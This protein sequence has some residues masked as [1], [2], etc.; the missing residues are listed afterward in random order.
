MSP[1]LKCIPWCDSEKIMW[2]SQPLETLQDPKYKYYQWELYN[3]TLYTGENH[4]TLFMVW[5]QYS[6]FLGKTLPMI[7]NPEYTM[8]LVSK[9]LTSQQT[10][11][12]I[13]V[14]F[15]I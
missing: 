1:I 7:Q 3:F 4:N 12:S 14:E 8:F 13:L 15:Q 2:V 5:S 6:Q 10:A 11:K 9:E